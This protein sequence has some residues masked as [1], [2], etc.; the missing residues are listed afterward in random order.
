MLEMF[1]RQSQSWL[2]WVAFG[3]IIIVFVFFFGPQAGGIT[4][5]SKTWAARVNGTRIYNTQLDATVG[6]AA[7]LTGERL[8]DEDFMSFKRQVLVDIATIHVLA[9]HAAASGMQVSDDELRCYIVNW[10][11]R[12]AVGEDFICRQFPR[13]YEQLFPNIDLGFYTDR[14]G[15]FSS[16][17]SQ[18][19]RRWFQ[20]SVESY[21]QF[22]RR[23][24]LALRYLE[25][26]SRGVP[27]TTA[28]AEFAWRLQNDT[29]DLE[30]VRFEADDDADLDAEQLDAF[31][32][33]RRDEVLAAWQ[34]QQERFTEPRA[35]QLRRIYL[36][37]PSTDDPGYAAA[38]ERYRNLLAEAQQDDADFAALVAEHSELDRERAEGGDMGQRTAQ[39]LSS[40][41][42][43]AF[44]GQGE[45]AIVGVEQ[46]YAW[47]ITRL[48][49]DRPERVRPFDEVAL[50][51]AAE[52]ARDERLAAQR[53]AYEVRAR[54]ILALAVGGASLEDA[55]ATEAAESGLTPFTVSS[56][57]PFGIEPSLPVIEGI[58]PQYLQ[59]IRTLGRDP[60][61]VPSIGRS[62]QLIGQAFALTDEQP[63]IDELVTVEGVHH[64]VRL[65]ERARPA[66]V[67]ADA[68]ADEFDAVQV[69]VATRLI[70]FRAVQERLLVH[71]SEPLPGLLQALLDEAD[72]VV[73]DRLFRVEA[74]GD[75]LM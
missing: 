36:R 4:P 7:R 43:A 69:Q 16:N 10:D 70:N 74:R 50:E 61:D 51:L 19:V 40:D 13:S 49:A 66:S 55:V 52:L 20:M 45:G 60:A 21:E 5:G 65:R 35:L 8:T 27:A 32:E 1:R 63:L 58:D 47:S 64:I 68:L 3:I 54:R 56:T 17:Y 25:L 57:G 31:L 24:L 34:A 42:F 23:E 15:N 48:D 67:P 26:L 72:V 44:E 28:Q 2:I 71:T 62:E 9:D 53:E 75:D 38:E 14:S 6:R 11:R 22:K 39:N 73:R 59:F 33:E 46:Q 37:R 29:I 30:F 18:D 12:Y 41:F